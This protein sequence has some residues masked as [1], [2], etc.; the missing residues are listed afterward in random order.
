[1]TVPPTEAVI[2]GSRGFALALL[3]PLAERMGARPRVAAHP[4]QAL[5][6]GASGLVVVEFMGEDS[7][8]AIQ[9]L[10]LHG[11]GPRVVVVV[12]EAQAAALGPL[13]A[14]GVE[15]VRWDG[16]PDGVLAAVA[17]RMAARPAAAQA[18]AAKPRAAA[19][20][21]GAPTAPRP[22]TVRAP[23]PGSVGG[24]PTVK[25]TPEA[26]P[27]G[28]RQGAAPGRSPTGGTPARTATGTA[29]AR[30]A[31][32]APPPAP[33][34]DLRAGAGAR[35]AAP[36]PPA[37]TAPAID[38]SLFDDVF[39]FAVEEGDAVDVDLD[40]GDPARPSAPSPGPSGGAWPTSVPGAEDA[41]G[42]LARG[43]G[44]AFDP[45]GSP[46]ACVAEVLGNLSEI[47][48]AVF[49][50]E[51]PP[52]DTEPIRRAAVMRV[53]VAAALASA[54]ARGAPVDS[55]AVSALL[56]EIDALLSDVSALAAEAPADLQSSLEAVRNALVKE[57]IDF[58]EAAQ[59]G[60]A[61]V[62]EAPRAPAP[63][64]TKTRVLTVEKD[65]ARATAE[66][67]R[68]PML[69][70]LALSIA[71]AAGYHGW[72]W[73]QRRSALATGF[74]GPPGMTSSPPRPGTAR[75]LVPTGS[76]G[77]PDPADVLRFKNTEAA[78]GNEVRELG[79]GTLV[80]LPPRPKAA[81]GAAPA[82]TRR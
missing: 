54:P 78:K 30:L 47:E 76:A 48:R 70:L 60:A 6:L 65:A 10:V 75:V 46:L 58:S 3:A 23:P 74:G 42:A 67:R 34:D 68:W 56:A 1:M 38:E 16:K 73:Y 11:A 81:T 14:L 80:V 7:L 69:V 2:A 28:E 5:E 53:R 52:I 8:R 21:P 61:E 27:G 62:E 20:S 32:A 19:P 79:D 77:R 18:P 66:R 51:P 55:G 22:A 41:A 24:A 15:T 25:A 29:V 36:L 9:D 43:L 26:W 45:P 17:R 4:T 44:G 63:R 64:V 40:S 37:P 50:V 12:R 82:E 71:A 59:S 13:Q 33:F 72:H 39:S 31:P 49:S 57:A 35:A